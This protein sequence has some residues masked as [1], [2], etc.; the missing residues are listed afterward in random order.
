MNKIK[1]LWQANYR[2]SK[3]PQ[4]AILFWMTKLIS[5]GLGESISDFSVKAIS[6]NQI[7]GALFTM[8]WSAILF[9]CFLWLQLATKKYKPAPY[10]L[11]VALLAVFGTFISDAVR[12]VLGIPL[13]V[14]TIF[15][16]VLM[17]LS[18]VLMKKVAGSISIHQIY[19]G[20]AELMYWISVSLS[21]IMGT[22]LGDYLGDS[23]SLGGLGLG[24]LTSGMIL[25]I[26]FLAVLAFRHFGRVKDDTLIEVIS[27]WIAYILTRPIGASFADYFG[28]SVFG[29]ITGVSIMIIVWLIL[30]IPLFMTNIRKFNK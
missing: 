26:I 1:Q 18:L 27:F 20:K 24:N 22:T 16:F 19:S 23:P 25:L 21:F 7:I 6:S 12:I 9:F 2:S 3:V 28:R 17:L 11:T 15:W 30:F 29:G 8:I 4:I 13:L 14:M 5:T 10:W